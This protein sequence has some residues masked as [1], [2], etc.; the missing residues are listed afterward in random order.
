M[1]KIPRRLDE[2]VPAAAMEKLLEVL[3]QPDISGR[4]RDALH[5]VGLHDAAP[6][7]KVRDA[8]QQARGWIDSVAEK[9]VGSVSSPRLL[10]ASGQMFTNSLST[11]PWGTS[12]AHEFA[13]TV[14]IY[15]SPVALAR[16]GEE[17]ARRHLGSHTVA[18]LS[19]TSEALRLLASGTDGV[20]GVVLSRL[21]AVRIAGLGDIRSMLA[22]SSNRLI[23]VG[24]SNG[25]RAEDWQLALT[26]KKQIVVLASPNNLSAVDKRQHRETAV[27]AAQQSGAKVI[28]LLADGVINQTLAERYGFPLALQALESGAD[29][30]VLP[31]QLLLGGPVGAIVI[32]HAEMVNATRLAAE[33]IGGLLGGASLWAAALTVDAAAM[34]EPEQSTIAAQLSVNPENLHNRARRLALQLTGRGEI[35]DAQE[36]QL[37]TPL[38]PSPWNRYSLSS[39]GVRLKPSGSLSDLLRQIA[40][41]ES[42][43]GLKLELIHEPESLSINLRFIPPQCDHELVLA[44]AGAGDQNTPSPTP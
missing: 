26:H 8:W 25:V 22:A 11:I 36:V 2:L 28:E 7:E 6:L 21:D 35:R 30:V 33:N 34:S 31:T 14:V 18:W 16:K 43:H 37:S 10:N 40:R 1:V 32:G 12:V 15:Q 5:K 19:S 13:S 27:T 24:A 38:G 9:V 42:Q 17:V 44:I 41:G 20:D 29:V 23:E 4:V 3:Q 39:W